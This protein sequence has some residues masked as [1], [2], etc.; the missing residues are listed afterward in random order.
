MV[1][2]NKGTIT[3]EMTLLIPL[4]LGIVYLYIMYLLFSFGLS[5]QMYEETEKLYHQE[6]TDQKEVSL[7]EN[8]LTYNLFHVKN[9]EITL[10]LKRDIENPV[11]YIRRWQLAAR[12]DS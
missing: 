11:A 5:K 4:I 2:N 7:S 1:S 9:Y 3:I 6:L 10:K 12:T 8:Q